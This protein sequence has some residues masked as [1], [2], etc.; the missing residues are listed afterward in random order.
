MHTYNWQ[1]LTQSPV[2]SNNEGYSFT[3]SQLVYENVT[4]INTVLD[5]LLY[6]GKIMSLDGLNGMYCQYIWK[7]AS[8]TIVEY[9]MH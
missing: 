7:N 6:V 8:F 2:H 5:E 3:F 9:K 4:R 1:P